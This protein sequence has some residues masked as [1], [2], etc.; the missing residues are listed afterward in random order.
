M[1]WKGVGFFQPI[2][3]KDGTLEAV[4]YKIDD[5]VKDVFGGHHDAL[6]ALQYASNAYWT[7]NA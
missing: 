1:L 7:Y 5:T 2:E 6:D 3:Y 4:L